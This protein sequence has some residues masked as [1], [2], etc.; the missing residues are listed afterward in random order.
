MSLTNYKQLAGKVVCYD[1]K[2]GM[3]LPYAPQDG[4]TAVI[5]WRAYCMLT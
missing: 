4:T 1:T 5:T 3:Q 2:Y